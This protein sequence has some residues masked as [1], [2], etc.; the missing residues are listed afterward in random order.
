MTNDARKMVG[1]VLFALLT[2]AILVGGFYFPLIGLGSAMDRSETV[3]SR[4]F[5]LLLFLPAVGLLVLLVAMLPAFRGRLLLS[6][7]IGGSLCIIPSLA[8]CGWTLRVGWEMGTVAGGLYLWA[9]WH[10][11]WPRLGRETRDVVRTEN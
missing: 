6:L 9:W 4:V 10:L 1:R 5:G 7:G 3:E 2:A 11:A 8:A